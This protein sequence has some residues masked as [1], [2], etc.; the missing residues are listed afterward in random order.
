MRFAIQK[1]ITEDGK[2][3]IILVETPLENATFTHALT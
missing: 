2:L 3:N 1:E